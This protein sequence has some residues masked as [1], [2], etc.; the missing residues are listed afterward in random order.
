MN[1]RNLFSA[2]KQLALSIV[3]YRGDKEEYPIVGFYDEVVYFRYGDTLAFKDFQNKSKVFTKELEKLLELIPDGYSPIDPILKPVITDNTVVYKAVT[4]DT[5]PFVLLA[6]QID[7]RLYHIHML[8]AYG[9]I[10]SI[11]SKLT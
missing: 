8:V 10:N 9:K 7:G 6:N 3:T 2:L 4:K 5:I 1:S 11:N